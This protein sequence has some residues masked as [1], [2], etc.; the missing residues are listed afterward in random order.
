MA[1]YRRRPV[2]RIFRRFWT[3]AFAGVTGLCYLEEEGENMN[4]VCLYGSPRIKGNSAAIAKKFCETAIKR[5][6]KVQS[7]VLNKLNFRGCQACYGCKDKS[8]KCV[9]KDDL[10]EVLDT[11]PNSDML[12]LASPVYY[13]DVSAQLKAFID[14]T[15]SFLVP[16]YVQATKIH[17]LEGDK[18]F[19]MILTQGS[20]D[21]EA[22]K[23]IFP[24]Y[25]TFFKWMG[26]EKSELI[27]ACGI[28]EPSDL[29][30]REDI[31]KQAEDLAEKLTA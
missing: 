28:M 22:F 8:D 7:W 29:K 10:T 20:A 19:V 6:A 31:F 4:I 3:P 26:F 30:S 25:S 2:S 11:V 14:R 13:G 1:S 16:D 27:H 9:I 5:G 18:T 15:Y 24:R 17:R 21:K 12:V 23:D